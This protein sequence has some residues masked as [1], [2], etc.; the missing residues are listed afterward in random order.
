MS[1]NNGGGWEGKARQRGIHM[2]SG[3]CKCERKAGNR[4]EKGGRKVGETRT[5]VRGTRVEGGREEGVS[6]GSVRFERG[7]WKGIAKGNSELRLFVCVC[8]CVCVCSYIA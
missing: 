5:A 8:V 3:P 4:R 1:R 7:Q 2:A 6:C